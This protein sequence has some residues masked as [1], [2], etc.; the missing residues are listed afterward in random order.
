MSI[1]KQ[2]DKSDFAAFNNLIV[3]YHD[4][5]VTFFDQ[6]KNLSQVHPMKPMTNMV[7]LCIKGSMTFEMSGKQLSLNAGDVLFTPP[8]VQI[9]NAQFSEDYECKVLG[10]S[11]RIIQGLLRDKIEVWNQAV[12]IN[13]TNLIHM[14]EV[15]KEEFNSYYALLISK[16]RNRD[17]TVHHE[18]LL[19]I[20]RALLLELCLILEQT[21]KTDPDAK[22]SQGKL[23]FNKFLNMISNNDVKR[24]PIKE[25]ADRLAITPKY[26]T[27]LCLKYSNKTASDWIVLYT[28][29]DIRFYLK[30]TSLSIKEISARLGFANMSHFGS[31]VRKHL[32]LSPSIIRG[33][34]QKL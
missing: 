3:D 34:E 10:L 22:V 2:N 17:T 30:S 16:I 21:T 9:T 24:R 8:N 31:Y 13:H 29:E 32:G 19:T 15:C 18:I 23:L 25:Y 33:R 4:G 26:L 5:D 6:V 12:Y 11:N 20:I 7:A 28:V 14:S 1:T 27:M